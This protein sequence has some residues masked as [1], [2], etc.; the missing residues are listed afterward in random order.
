MEH[1]VAFNATYT[2]LSS[3]SYFL[4]TNQ[5]NTQAATARIYLD[6]VVGSGHDFG[7]LS[8]RPLGGTENKVS[9]PRS[10]VS[11]NDV[12]DVIGLR[13]GLQRGVGVGVGVAVADVVGYANEE[14][15]DVDDEHG[16]VGARDAAEDGAASGHADV[17]VAE[18]GQGDGQPDGDGVADYAEAGVEQQEADPAK[19]TR[20][21]ER[22]RPGDTNASSKK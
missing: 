2:P 13:Q 15:E 10:S 18:D 4:G 16:L 11:R 19:T 9:L 6:E 7:R 8:L 22:Q 14:G 21:E 17:D 12:C 3:G 5:S 20:V 1:T